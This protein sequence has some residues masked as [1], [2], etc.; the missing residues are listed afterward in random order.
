MQKRLIAALL[1]ATALTLPALAGA[2]TTLTS[3]PS[4]YVGADPIYWRHKGADINDASSVGARV[5]LGIEATPYLAFEVH[6]GTLGK[7]TQTNQSQELNHVYGAFARATL[8]VA[9]DFRLY[10]LAG[11]SEVKLD[12]ED[13]SADESV[14]MSMDG[15][16][17][18]GGIEIDLF[19]QANLF[20]EGLRYVDR[21]SRFETVGAG[22]RYVF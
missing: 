9:N 16:S 1:S 17:F 2:Q 7:D 3:E 14:S 8:P 4:F 15:F 6:G 18:G 19:E 12:M 10:S 21:D 11:Y 13:M 20:L 5:R 22:I